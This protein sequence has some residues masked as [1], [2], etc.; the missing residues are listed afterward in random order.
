MM[1]TLFALLTLPLISCQQSPSTNHKLIDEV[2]K[3]ESGGHPCVTFMVPT[4]VYGVQKSTPTEDI[5]GTP[6]V[7][8][9]I[10]KITESIAADWPMD[11]DGFADFKLIGKATNDGCAMSVTGPVIWDEYAF[12]WFSE[13]GGVRGSYAFKLEGGAWQVAERLEEGYW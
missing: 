12:L 5:L 1:R 7:D 3:R 9:D 11:E 6:F 10:R 13:P 2:A 8:P 4:H